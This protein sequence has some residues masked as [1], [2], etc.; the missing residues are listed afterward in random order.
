MVGSDDVEEEE[1]VLDSGSDA[2]EERKLSGSAIR[3]SRGMG[4]LAAWIARAM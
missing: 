1:G 2:E 4:G 3:R